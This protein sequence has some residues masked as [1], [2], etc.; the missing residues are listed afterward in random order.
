MATT[1]PRGYGRGM[2]EVGT[3]GLCIRFGV[4]RAFQSQ[5]RAVA[6]VSWLDPSVSTTAQSGGRSTTPPHFNSATSH[7]IYEGI[8]PYYHLTSFYLG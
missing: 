2:R 6:L 3:A 7:I 1:T 5:L 4:A 8:P